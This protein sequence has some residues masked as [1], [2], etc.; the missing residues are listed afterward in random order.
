MGEQVIPWDNTPGQ[1]IVTAAAAP[2]TSGWYQC[3]R[4]KPIT[5]FVEVTVGTI[6]I[7]TR[8]GKAQ[9]F[10][11]A[12]VTYGTGVRVLT[13]DFNADIEVTLSDTGTVYGS[14]DE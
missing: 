4:S 7:A 13:F 8:E 5:L 1:L 6:V 3:R 12:F 11:E 9:N 2:A 14:R 10:D